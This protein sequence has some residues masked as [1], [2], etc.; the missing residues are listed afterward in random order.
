MQF[1]IQC[2]GC[3]SSLRGNAEL[4]GKRVK[5][6]KCGHQFRLAALKDS[7]P[8]PLANRQA[9]EANI[10]SAQKPLLESTQ[11][12]R[13]E[14]VVRPLELKWA[15]RPGVIITQARAFGCGFGSEYVYCYS[16]SAYIE[17][18]NLKHERRFRIKVGKADNDPIARICQQISGN[19]TAVSESPVVLLVFQT[20][21]SRHLE[22]WLHARLERVT[23]AGG[24]EWFNTSPEEL[25]EL[26]RDYLHE[27]SGQ[28]DESATHADEAADPKVVRR[29]RVTTSRQQSGGVARG[30]RDADGLT[31]K[32][33][34]FELWLAAAK[35]GEKLDLR[36]MVEQFPNRSP[37]T[38]QIWRTRFNNCGRGTRNRAYPR[39]ALGRAE[40]IIE[41]L[42]MLKGEDGVSDDDIEQIKAATAPLH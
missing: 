41:A 6:V 32:D 38:L 21:A 22:R 13:D 14:F 2:P 8:F 23:D 27:A 36:T 26:Y 3:A 9:I 16:Y 12:P 29:K 37:N 35:R 24:S 20:L 42:K 34:F 39:V 4:A 33:K 10:Q 28:R 40:E 30:A 1:R 5:C 11:S 17:L 31:D 15:P 18:A 25:I 19:K 7:S